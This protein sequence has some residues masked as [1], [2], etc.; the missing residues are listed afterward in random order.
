[1]AC[2]PCCRAVDLDLDAAVGR[3]LVQRP[4]QPTSSAI[5]AWAW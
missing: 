3:L 5:R 2:S 1:M 4:V